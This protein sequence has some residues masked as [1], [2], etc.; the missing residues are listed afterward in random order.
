[1]RSAIHHSFGD[2]A[3]V[4]TLGESPLPEPG[5]G[6]VWTASVWQDVF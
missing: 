5:A 2:P 6:H 4:L 1:M 3:E